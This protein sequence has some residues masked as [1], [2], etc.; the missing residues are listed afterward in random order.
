MNASAY[1]WPTRRY[2]D[3]AAAG[4]KLAIALEHFRGTDAI[5]VALPRGGVPIA[6]EIANTLRLPLDILLVRKL[7]APGQPE[8]AM[9]AIATG[10]VI[11][12][13][14]RVVGAERV[15]ADVLQAVVDRATTELNR[16]ERAYRNGRPALPV[17]GRMILLV[18]DG[19]AT[20]ATL[21]AAIQALGERGATYIAV[22]V[23]VASPEIVRRLEEVVD[24][25]V[26]PYQPSGLLA[27]G[28]AYAD[29]GQVTDDEVRALLAY[30][31]SESVAQKANVGVEEASR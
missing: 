9:G 31:A 8:L 28:Q 11:V 27:V 10:G 21:F 30:G 2:Q 16:R 26:C 15:E 3:R 24:E 29:F 19:V 5:V 4:R 6:F 20:G 13:N 25:V 22:A 23:P 18:D 17:R 1:S 14:E 7:G 12:L